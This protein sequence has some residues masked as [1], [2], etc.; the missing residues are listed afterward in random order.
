MSSSYILIQ[1]IWADLPS[2]MSKLCLSLFSGS[3][4]FDEHSRGLLP[5]VSWPGPPTSKLLPITAQGLKKMRQQGSC[6]S[7]WGKCLRYPGHMYSFV[8]M[9]TVYVH[10][11][12]PNYLHRQINTCTLGILHFI[13][14]EWP[15]GAFSISLSRLSLPLS[16]TSSEG[17]LI[18][19]CVSV[20]LPFHSSPTTAALDQSNSGE[21]MVG[22]RQG[23]KERNFNRG[24]LS[25]HMIVDQWHFPVLKRFSFCLTWEMP[26]WILSCFLTLAFKWMHHGRESALKEC[27]PFVHHDTVKYLLVHRHISHVESG[28]Y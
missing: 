7:G 15:T 23:K 4:S 10:V 16:S 2:W 28:A 18:L 19:C 26:L 21:D 8:H 14:Y 20:N 13:S 5:S 27:K 12:T 9:P 17:R 11:N 24:T 3:F 25:S 6:L 1:M 22:R